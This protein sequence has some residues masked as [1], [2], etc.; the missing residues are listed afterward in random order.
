[1]AR[2]R[3]TVP[4]DTNAILE[5]HRTG[6]WRALTERL[7]RG[8]RGGLRHR[9]PDRVP[10]PPARAPARSSGAAE[11]AR[12]RSCERGAGTRGAGGQG[13]RT[14]ARSGRSLA[15]G[16]RIGSRDQK[17]SPKNPARFNPALVPPT[18]ILTGGMSRRSGFAGTSLTVPGDHVQV[19]GCE[20]SVPKGL[21]QSK[22]LSPLSRRG[23][24]WPSTSST[25]VTLDKVDR[26][27]QLSPFS[28]IF[29]RSSFR[30]LS[31]RACRRLL[32]WSVRIMPP[33][34]ATAP[35]MA[36]RN[37]AHPLTITEAY[38]VSLLVRIRCLAHA[39]SR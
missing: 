8:D 29:L 19:T 10:A 6:F 28:S 24:A 35:A 27:R 16:T 26:L 38:P 30:G 17:R 5:A 31:F 39:P 21:S 32:I 3:G 22:N 2:H 33:S 14:R 9:A 34:V 25:P 1:M 37:P 7:R 12:G 4:V 23:G 20:K 11:R 18:R 13:W 36:P 15:L